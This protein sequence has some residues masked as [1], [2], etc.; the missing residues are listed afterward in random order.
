MLALAEVIG[1]LGYLDME[2]HPL[3][4]TSTLP[5][6][7][8]PTRSIVMGYIHL[9]KLRSFIQDNREETYYGELA[10]PCPYPV[11]TDVS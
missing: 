6:R 5:A 7:C 3:P 10:N 8:S 4:G 1:C 9:L 11:R 2:P